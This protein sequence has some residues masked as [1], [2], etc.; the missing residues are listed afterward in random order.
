VSGL[1]ER[2]PR[3][4]WL[5]A[6]I[7]LVVLAAFAPRLNAS[8][9]EQSQILLGQSEAVD[10]E[11]VLE[12]FFPAG[13]GSPMIIVVPVDAAEDALAIVAADDAVAEARI[14][15]RNIIYEGEDLALIEATL[16]YQADSEEALAAVE[17]LRIELRSTD[18]N[19][20]V[21]GTSASNLDTRDAASRDLWTIVPIVLAVITLILALLLRSIIAPLLL[22]ATTVVSY[23]AA[24]G[25]SALVFDVGF[26]FPGADPAVPLFAFVFLVALG[27]DYNIFLTT[28]IR[29]E[30]LRRGTRPGTLIGLQTTGGVITSAGI[31]LATTFA[32]LAVIP[33]LFLVQIAFIVALGVLI[34]TM[35]VRSLLVPGLFYQ[36]GPSIWWPSRVRT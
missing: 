30:A 17:R 1:V 16:A 35:V 26:G 15:Q 11:Q 22:I 2:R 24:L 31:V 14:E 8:G 12:R 23:L 27:I 28:R 34:D 7:V 6:A 32:A 21:G 10:G 18:P 13:S 3:A 9:V 29:E 33:I 5:S 25:I 19:A 36:I 20:L 4:V